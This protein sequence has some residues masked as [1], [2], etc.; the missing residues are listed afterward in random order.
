MKHLFALGLTLS[1]FMLL[2]PTSAASA[3][4]DQAKVK[5]ALRE[6]QDF[7]G[8]W[9]GSGSKKFNPT[10]RDTFWSETVQ[11]NWRFKGDDVWLEVEFKG[12]KLFKIAE[13]RYLLDKKQYQM[14]ATPVEGKEKLV[15]LGTLKDEKLTFERT[16]GK[17]KEVQRIRMNTAAEGIRFIYL[18]DR[19]SEGATIWRQ[20]AMVQ[21][22]KIGESLA[23]KEKKGPE[24]VVSGGLGTSTVSYMGETFYVCCSG[25]RDAFNENPKKYVD[26]FKAKKGKK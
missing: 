5:D 7:I 9:K 26:E 15:F 14:K 10:P 23:R 8:G 20:E 3:D 2:I 1:L 12:G 25:C 16:D 17:T 19:Q 24:C 18:V 21:T 6:L 11:W 13:V 22:T 4:K